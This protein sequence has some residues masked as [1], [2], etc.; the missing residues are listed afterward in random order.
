MNHLANIKQSLLHSFALHCGFTL[1]V[2]KIGRLK[3]IAHLRW[4]FD[5][6][7][8]NVGLDPLRVVSVDIGIKN[9]STCYATYKTDST[10]INS[11][12]VSNLHETL[13]PDDPLYS[14]YSGE[15]SKNKESSE[16]DRFCDD[17]SDLT[18]SNGSIKDEKDSGS[19]KGGSVNDKKGSVNDK[20]DSVNDK[21]GSKKNKKDSRIINDLNKEVFE[22]IMNDSIDSK[23]YLARLAVGAVD[24]ILLKSPEIP[25]IITVECQRT[26]SNSNKVTLPNVILN[27]LFEYM[28]YATIAARQSCDP[29]LANIIL[30]PMNSNK[31][32]NFWI[33][34]FIPRQ[35]MT[36]AKT[37]AL[38]ALLFYSWFQDP[39]ISPFTF[40]I[41]RPVP[42]TLNKLSSNDKFKAVALS[43]DLEI[44]LAKKDDLI[45]SFLYNV[46]IAKQIQHY[47]E[48]LKC[49]PSPE[50][51]EEL[52][53]EWDKQH[54]EHVSFLSK[55]EKD[56]S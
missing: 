43:L 25:H 21:K 18:K 27:L 49:E 38:R 33:S 44:S 36:P 12:S 4:T 22:N 6:I 29:K 31:M 20:K 56:S 24:N 48:F 34:R 52:I 15:L 23:S 11:W 8:R 51:Y 40:E 41:L 47:K 32:V 2:N 53:R 28:L 9:F 10:E 17:R 39:S 46:A 54:E 26:R 14:R 1:H 55:I 42:K 35:K 5:K 7:L 30:L 3:A 16:I 37:K 45:D 19:D 13:G 50:A